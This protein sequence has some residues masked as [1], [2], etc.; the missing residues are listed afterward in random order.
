MA[1]RDACGP[2]R[3]RSSIGGSTMIEASSEQSVLE[4]PLEATDL[5]RRYRGA[6]RWAIRG[7]TCSLQAGSVTALVGPNGAGKSSLIRCLIGFEPADE[8]RVRV[9]GW[10]P[11]RQRAG[12]LTVVGY[13]SQ[14]PR[15][16]PELSAE[17]H[18]TFLASF[19]EGVDVGACARDLEGVGVDPRRPAGL[20]SGGEQTQLCLSLAM[21]AR[22]QVLILD[23]PL[24]SLDPLARRDFLS[25]LQTFVSTTGAAALL[26]SHIVSDIELVSDRIMILASGT[27]LL[28]DGVDA[29]LDGHRIRDRGPASI[30]RAGERVIGTFAAGASGERTL[31]VSIDEDLPH[32]SLDDLVL[33]YLAGARVR[34]AA[35]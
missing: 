17:D 13:M 2:S 31:I 1:R 12:A 34:A 19:R 27:V 3:R 29:A 16:Y 4:V 11:H 32:P 26:S 28:L 18:L 10:D 25:R 7:V 30:G 20:L 15:L 21:A 33:G 35:R 22:P 6:G 5:G 8:G 14:M 9:C 23:E 24:A